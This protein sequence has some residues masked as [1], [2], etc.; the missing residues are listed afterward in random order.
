MSIELLIG[1]LELLKEYCG[2]FGIETPC[3]AIDR[4]VAVVRQ[5]KAD[6]PHVQSLNISPERVQRAERIERVEPSQEAIKRV[7]MSIAF[8][9]YELCQAE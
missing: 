6:R 3:Q 5:H 9:F 1:K 2:P 8:R 4:C 7:A